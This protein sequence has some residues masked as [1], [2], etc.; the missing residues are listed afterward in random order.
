MTE[1]K[2]IVKN[3]IFLLMRM[4]LILVIGLYSSR[5]LLNSLGVTD[6]GIYNLIAGILLLFTVI[7]NALTSSVQRFFNVSRGD[8]NTLVVYFSSSKYLF[9]IIGIF[10]FIVGQVFSRFFIEY[11]NI[12]QERIDDAYIVFYFSLSSL[13][14][15]IVRIPYNALLISYEKMG[16]IS[17]ISILEASLKL[18]LI[19]LME[20]YI[21]NYLVFYS[22]IILIISILINIIYLI[23]IKK[24]LKIIRHSISLIHMTSLIKFSGWS[25]LG[26]SG[27]VI[28]QQ[29]IAIFLNHYFSVVLNAANSLANQI[30]G[31]LGGFL[32]SFQMAYSPLLMRT[33]YEKKWALC[34]VYINDFTRYSLYIAIPIIIPIYIYMPDII[35]L[36]IL[37]IPEKTIFISRIYL[38]ILLIDVVSA[39]LWIFV[40]AHGEISK[41][42][43]VIFFLT[44]TSIPLT[45]F[46]MHYNS[47]VELIMYIKLF[48]SC[49]VL[50]YRFNFVFYLLKMNYF[51]YVFNCIIK[52]LIIFFL[53]IFLGFYF[54]NNIVIFENK[55]QNSILLFFLI[56]I[57]TLI[58]IY[59]FGLNFSERRVIVE[60][61]S[62][63]GKIL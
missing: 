55:M 30:Y 49:V 43:I 26:S 2:R 56:F 54:E 7:T 51:Q 45:V 20:Y 39:P 41:Y 18:F 28:S 17:I 9:I 14:F 15:Q 12:P 29:S 34:R 32:N 35:K 60:K 16:L 61:L 38:L 37:N 47:S 59:L 4:F 36:W 8:L 52:P 63:M 5:L 11:L 31:S 58:L 48:T 46:L 22:I 13:F 6:F 62:R 1:K 53:M 21:V 23:I 40:N 10:I 42:Q 19:I 57:L 25:F 3:T 50:V 24:H 33:V 44:L 27:V